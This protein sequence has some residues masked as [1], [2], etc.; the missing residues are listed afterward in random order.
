MVVGEYTHVHMYMYM[1]IMFMSSACYSLD[2]DCGLHAK[3]LETVRFPIVNRLSIPNVF[4]D[5]YIY[6]QGH[7]KVY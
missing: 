3:L 4:L 7:R 6:I 1:Y 2:F 5:N